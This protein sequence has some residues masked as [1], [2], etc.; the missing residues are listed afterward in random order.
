MG[1]N[2][3][4]ATASRF[5]AIGLDLGLFGRIVR[6]L[7]GTAMVVGI[8]RDLAN[9]QSVSDVLGRGGGIFRALACGL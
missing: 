5:G 9:V 4:T 3:A 7:L 2:Q 6:L 8:F 1:I